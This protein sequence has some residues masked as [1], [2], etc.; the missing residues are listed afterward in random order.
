MTSKS[1]PEEVLA[2]GPARTSTKF[3][4]TKSYKY[5]IFNVVTTYKSV[6]N[7]YNFKLTG[8][9]QQAQAISLRKSQKKDKL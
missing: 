5:S 1:E 6:R 2:K 8:G 7:I 3:I 4:N 9:M